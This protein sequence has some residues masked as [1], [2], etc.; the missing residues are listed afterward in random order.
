MM[1]CSI[2]RT[3]S[4]SAG[5]G[6]AAQYDC[7]YFE[8]SAAEDYSSVLA[9][10][11]RLLLD[12]VRL[13]DRQPALQSL[14]ITEDRCKSSTSKSHSTPL[15][16]DRKDEAASKQLATPTGNSRRSTAA[17]KLFNKGFKIFNS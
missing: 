3:V 12:V 7:A 14:F 1:L 10:F 15:A 2:N 11:G 6:L 9:A 16:D 13:L 4:R 8:T 5:E 17:F